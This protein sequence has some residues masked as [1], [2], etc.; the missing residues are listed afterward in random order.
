MTYSIVSDACTFLLYMSQERTPEQTHKRNDYPY[1]I[2]FPSLWTVA[3]QHI[4][5]KDSSRL[6]LNGYSIDPYLSFPLFPRATWPSRALSPSPRWCPPPSFPPAVATCLYP[7]SLLGCGG[8][9]YT[10]TS[11][12]GTRK[13]F[14]S[15]PAWHMDHST[16]CCKSEEVNC[17]LWSMELLSRKQTFP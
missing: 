17:T 16:W 3:N 14:C 8:W 9:T 15:P 1:C 5:I 4:S 12:P 13:D 7:W 2:Q 11:G 10:S 6:P